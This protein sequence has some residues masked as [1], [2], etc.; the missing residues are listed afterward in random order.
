[1]SKRKTKISEQDL[2]ELL[3][4]RTEKG[5]SVLYD[6]YSAAIFGVVNRIVRSEEIAADVSQDAFVKIW[7]NLDNYNASKGTIFTWMLNIA[8]NTAIDRIRSQEYI[9]TRQNLEI[10]NYVGI[11]DNQN[12]TGLNIDA[13]GL[14]NLVDKLRP[15]Y[16][17]LIDLV[18]FKGYT[19]SEIADEFD[20]PLGTIKTRIKSAITSLRTY[21]SELIIL[22]LAIFLNK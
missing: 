18:Y 22:L 3:R 2:L 12:N 6:N 15:E 14:K 13:I 5:F 19:Q 17:Q 9:Q 11:I 1:M 21:M 16:K 20:I 4:T 8:R 7:K 10:E